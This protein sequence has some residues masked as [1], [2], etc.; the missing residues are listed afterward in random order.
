MFEI[1]P[2]ARAVAD[3]AR[4]LPAVVADDHPG[5]PCR[6]CLRDAAVGEPV[7]LLTYAPLGRPGPY[8]TSGPIWVHADGCAPWSGPGVPE[9]LRRRL[10]SLRAYDAGD[11]MVVADVTDGT[12]LEGLAARMLDDP[13]VRVIHV[14][15]AR[16]GCYAC[17]IER[18]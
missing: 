18:S 7:R 4:D 14:H 12:A 10:L 9:L 15:L 2:L 11:R 5:F 3:A 16:P 17:R 13:R 6:V 1:I 8:A